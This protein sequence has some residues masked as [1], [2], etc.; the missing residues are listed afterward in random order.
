MAYLFKLFLVPATA[1]VVGVAVF[2]LFLFS[3]DTN[4]GIGAL[5]LVLLGHVLLE[6]IGI[7][8]S[9]K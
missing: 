3:G 7:R 8:E 4:T 6:L 2:V 1:V 5:I 9:L